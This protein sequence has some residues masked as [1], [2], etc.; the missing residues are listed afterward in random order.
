[1][2]NLELWAF[3]KR[4]NS[5]KLPT[6]GSGAAF[7][8]ELKEPFAVTELT[9][10]LNLGAQLVAPIY[11]YARVEELHRYYFITDWAYTGGLWYAHLAV[12]VLG[13]Y[14]DEIGSSRQYVTRSA[15]DFDANLIDSA[16]ITKPSNIYRLY[17]LV[18]PRDFY[19]A[20]VYGTQGLV[21]L[22]VIGSSSG[23]VGAVTYYAMSFPVF[24]SF[25][26]QMLGGISWAQI[27]GS[28]ISLELQKALIN[29]T[30]YIVSCRWY[31]I[32]AAW[33]AQGVQVSQID[34]GWWSFHLTGTA[35]L[36]P[37]VDNSLYEFYAEMEIPKHPQMTAEGCAYLQAS[38]YSTYTL[39]MLPFGVFEI[40]SLELFNHSYLWVKVE[41][42]LLT[43]DAVL[44]VG[45]KDF[46][47]MVPDQQAFLV[48]EGRIGVDLP[49][50]QV[51]ADLTNYKQ[52][53]VLGV[54][55]GAA[56]IID[57]AVGGGF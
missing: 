2:V 3:D 24:S 14:K 18:T 26:Y 52:A 22:G 50:G 8:G 46:T 37:S 25:M 33:F 6:T 16:Y 53:L 10:S 31:P 13:T 19:G 27:S 34:L 7:I 12:D 17:S 9:V 20:D 21:V 45:A 30:Q 55:T 57:N 51:R 47:G 36:L 4:V 29:P 41:T 42:N 15:S 28:E 49:I 1:M 5:T 32:S 39:K 43:G 54:A 40:D 38:P 35:R 56:G 23:A 48:T 11:N 44:K